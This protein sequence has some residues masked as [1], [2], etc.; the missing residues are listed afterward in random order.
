[1]PIKTDAV[2]EHVARGSKHVYYTIAAN[3]LIG[4]V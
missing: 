1:M 2:V 4:V 3:V